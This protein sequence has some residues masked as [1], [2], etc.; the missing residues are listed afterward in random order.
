MVEVVVGVLTTMGASLKSLGL[1]FIFTGWGA[2]CL[3]TGL[4]AGTLC[5]LRNWSKEIFFGGEG[6]AT[7][8]TTGFGA[9]LGVGF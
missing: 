7:S 2:G 6:L 3:F 9:G 8:L 1:I 4:G 5:C